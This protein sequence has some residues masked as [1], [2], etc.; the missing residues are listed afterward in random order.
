MTRIS[1]ALMPRRHRRSALFLVAPIV[2]AVSG[3]SPSAFTSPGQ[4]QT[5]QQKPISVISELV[6]VPVSVTDTRGNFVPGLSREDFRVHED[7]HPR[8]IALFEHE[9][10]PATVGLLVDHSGSM[11]SK[12]P[13]IATAVSGFTHASDPRDEMFVVDFGDEVTVE[14]PGGKPFT[15]SAA[16]IETAIL[17]V[18]AQGR[19]ALYDAVA[20]GLNHLRLAHWQKR[21]LIIVSDGGD[22]ASWYKYPQILEWARQSQ[23]VIYSIGLVDERGEE[24]NPRVLDKLCQDTGGIAFF[25][26]SGSAI[27]DSTARIS[28]DLR[29]QYILGFVPEARVEPDAFHKIQVQVVATQHGKLH[30]R[31]RPGYSVAG[32]GDAYPKPEGDKP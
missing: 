12:L 2:L 26:G 16:D 3:M 25:P 29:E 28:R 1:P 19:T 11:G 8:E 6:V 9:D 5:E 31:T 30:V 13:D 4:S 22:N 15:S 23:V 17:G 7:N 27:M 21:A 32:S 18:S 10:T 14:L 20:A 24:E